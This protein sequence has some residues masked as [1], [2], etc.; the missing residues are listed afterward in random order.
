MNKL[1]RGKIL[2]FIFVG[3]ILLGIIALTG[4]IG[5]ETEDT[6]QSEEETEEYEETE[7]ETE[8]TEEETDEDETVKYTIAGQ[9]VTE[10][11]ANEFI[12]CLDESEVLIY[13]A[14]WCS[15]CGNL[16]ESL[17]G[18]ELV[19]PIWIE[20]TEEEERCNEEKQAGYVPEMHIEGELVDTMGPETLSEELGC[21][22]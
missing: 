14:E 1:N 6:E 15:A 21:S 19:D 7:G 8:E 10:T 2:S 18:Y 12:D 13:G 3:I 16:A 5:E 20:C 22:L 17:G 9:E 11:E 4:C